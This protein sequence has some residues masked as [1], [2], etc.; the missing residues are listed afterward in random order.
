MWDVIKIA[1]QSNGMT[2]RFIAIIAV[3]AMGAWLMALY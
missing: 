1:I 3:L 2:A